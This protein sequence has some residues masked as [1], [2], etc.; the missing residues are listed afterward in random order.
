MSFSESRFITNARLSNDKLSKAVAD[1]RE[2]V[3]SDNTQLMNEMSAIRQEIVTLNGSLNR[4]L[5]SLHLPRHQSG[6]GGPVG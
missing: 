1:L 5:G 2:E 4:I 6:G 3:K